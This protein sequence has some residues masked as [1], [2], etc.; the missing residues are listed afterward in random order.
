MLASVEPFFDADVDSLFHLYLENG[1]IQLD[2]VPF[3]KR[4]RV[5][6]WLMSDIFGLGQPRSKDAEKAIETA[7]ELQLEKAPS[8]EKV[9][10]ISDKLI[11]VLAPDDEF[12][13]LWTYFAE[14]RGVRFDARKNAS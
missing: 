8:Q 10:E 11:Q 2:E 13:P 14:Q 6:Q 3:V 5:D 7:N 9:Q 1:S 12:W 4:G